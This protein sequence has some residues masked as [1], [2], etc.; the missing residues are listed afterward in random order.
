[1][2]GHIRFLSTQNQ[3]KVNF[4]KCKNIAQKSK[5]NTSQWKSLDQLIF[6]M[7]VFNLHLWTF[8]LQKF[9]LILIG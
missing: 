7:F 5:E 8:S 9:S 6:S 1:M 4:Q 3:L 2:Y